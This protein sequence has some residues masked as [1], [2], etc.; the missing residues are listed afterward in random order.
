MRTSQEVARRRK[1]RRDRSSDPI[2]KYEVLSM[3]KNPPDTS[4][5]FFVL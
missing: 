4:G 5:G 2:E 1:S 3:K